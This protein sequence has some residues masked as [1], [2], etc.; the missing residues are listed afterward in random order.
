MSKYSL[1]GVNIHPET[2]HN[3]NN[4][5]KVSSKKE[6]FFD[7]FECTFNGEKIIVEKINEFDNKPLVEFKLKKDNKVIICKALLEVG[8]ENNLFLYEKVKKPT[9]K[10]EVITEKTNKVVNKKAIKDKKRKIEENDTKLINSMANEAIKLLEEKQ[11]LKE[12]EKLE[13]AKRIEKARRI[14]EERLVKEAKKLLE[15]KLLK[16]KIDADTKKMNEQ[17][18]IIEEEE[19]IEQEKIRLQEE[20]KKLEAIKLLEEER[21]LKEELIRNTPFYDNDNSYA[22]DIDTKYKNITITNESTGA[23]KIFES[24]G[25]PRKVVLNENLLSYHNIIN[26]ETNLNF[27]IDIETEEIVNQKYIEPDDMGGSAYAKKINQ[28]AGGL[29]NIISDKTRINIFF[30]N[31]G[32]MNSSLIPLQTMVSNNLKSELLPF[33]NNDGDAYDNNVSIINFNAVPTLSTFGIPVIE[34]SVV[35]GGVNMREIPSDFNV[36]NIMFQDENNAKP[37]SDYTGKAE[38]SRPGGAT[39]LKSSV[40]FLTGGLEV[41]NKHRA[42]FNQVIRTDADG[43]GFKTML[44]DLSSLFDSSPFNQQTSFTFDVVDGDTPENYA[45]LISTALSSVSDVIN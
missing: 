37:L 21:K 43:I 14:E 24:K 11:K 17:L 2:T 40:H 1:F 5:L 36:I 41:N 23:I 15:E 8:K 29:G 16:E 44:Q 3:K 18:K 27:T 28:T 13:E 22:L 42:I 25:I 10:V 34:N 45:S 35:L 12:K 38:D 39:D 7:I 33:F 20:A 31:S 30:D 19:K 9:K 26:E 32:S 4:I 6:I